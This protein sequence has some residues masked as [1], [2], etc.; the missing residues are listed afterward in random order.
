MDPNKENRQRKFLFQELLIKN[1]LGDIRLNHAR[2]EVREAAKIVEKY[3]ADWRI[4][5]EKL[6]DLPLSPDWLRHLFRSETGMS[7]QQYQR[8]CQLWQAAMLLS[9]SSL[10]VSEIAET[11]GLPEPSYF[12][13]LF[14]Q[15]YGET[16]NAFRE[17]TFWGRRTCIDLQPE[18]TKA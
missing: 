11:I 2:G 16:P 3:F 1:D 5:E 10:S 8:R 14:R 18:G 17:N 6:R 13:K 12:G 15:Q 7:I 4:C 9:C